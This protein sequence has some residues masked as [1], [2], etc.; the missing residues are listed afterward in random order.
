S[1]DKFVL[2]VR[3]SSTTAVRFYFETFIYKLPNQEPI[4]EAK[5]TGVW[6]GKNY[7]PVPLRAE[8]LTKLALFNMQHETPT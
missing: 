7:R 5:A 6:L 2:K 8:V 4:L 3:I 1:G